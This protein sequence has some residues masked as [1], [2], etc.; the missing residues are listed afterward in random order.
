MRAFFL[1]YFLSIFYSMTT[2]A[3]IYGAL[4]EVLECYV[5]VVICKSEKPT[6]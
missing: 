6:R 5:F 3:T 1:F 2:S 4:V